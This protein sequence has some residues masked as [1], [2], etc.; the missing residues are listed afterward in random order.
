MIR[1]NQTFFRD[2]V[3]RR[4]FMKLCAALAATMGLSTKA[5]AE[6]AHSVGSP[7]RPPVIWIGAQECTGCTESLLRA[8]HPTIENLLLDVVSMEYHEVLSAAFGEQ[9]EENKHRAIEQYKG[10]YVLVVDGSIPMKDGGVY[11]MVAGKP[12]VEH[13]RNAA[14]HAAAVIAI[15][16]CAAWGG[17]AASGP[18]PTGAVSLQDI[19][20]GKTVINIPGCPPN[21]HNFLATV[22]HIITYQRP[23]AL[24]AKNRPEFA[25]ARL[26]HENCERRP[27]FDAG[28]FAKQF[29]DEGH[30]QGWC[31]YHLGCKGPETYGNCST[32]EFCD[33]GG[34]IWPVGIGH[35][36]YGCNEQ[37]IGFTKG[38]AQLASVENPTPRNAKPEVGSVEGGHVSPTAMGLL[39]GVVGL[40]AGVSLM[41]VKEL[42]RQQKTQRKDDEQPPSKE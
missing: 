19:L 4:D 10:K 26:I 40:V 41:A 33:V 23:P 15:G 32:L 28:R 37:G 14:E 11:C 39:G 42:G 27:H 25:Y 12:I 7:Q 16:S 31:L 1:E 38:I 9:A 30:R 2:G 35:P 13:I 29:G 22:A 5:A 6:I 34:G 20:P 18:N 36:C 24:D 21:P 3:N 17:V 8:T